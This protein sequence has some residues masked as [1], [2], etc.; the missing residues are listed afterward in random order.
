M[1]LFVAFRCGKYTRDCCGIFSTKEQAVNV[2]EEY[3]SEEVDEHHYFTVTCFNLN[4]PSTIQPHPTGD[5][6][7]LIMEPPLIYTTGTPDYD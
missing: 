3:K 7:P 1:E 2:V 4:S 6:Y 5:L